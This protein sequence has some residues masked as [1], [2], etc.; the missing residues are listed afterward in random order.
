MYGISTGVQEI[1]KDREDVAVLMNYQ[2]YVVALG[3]YG[4]SSSFQ[5]LKYVLEWCMAL[6]REMLKK[7]R[8]YGT[9]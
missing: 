5:G 9:T 7:R 1:E 2:W 8:A 6:M 3:P 4:L